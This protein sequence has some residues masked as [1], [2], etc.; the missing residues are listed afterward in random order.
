[1]F[2]FGKP[3]RPRAIAFDTVGTLIDLEPLRPLIT[4]MGL[5]GAGLEGWIGAGLRDAFALTASG[6]FAP[7]EEVLKGALDQVLAEQQLDP[8]AT[9]KAALF[10]RMLALPARS[11]SSVALSLLKE[12]GIAL[13]AFTNS[14]LATAKAMLTSG[15]IDAFFTGIV[16]TG[17]I[18]TF[19]PSG[20][21]YRHC[22]ERAG[23][24]PGDLMLVAA[25]PWDI[26]GAAVAGCR[27]G[28]LAVQRPMSPVFRQ[29][30]L[31]AERLPDLAE[32]ICALSP[33]LA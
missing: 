12:Q 28:Y 16:T 19:K 27:T 31:I 15:G 8:S 10:T 20:A 4:H 25:H 32:A 23:V 26:H 29:P 21:V 1:M 24:A 11:G 5:P 13:Y 18:E 14:S 7:F 9:D 2:G 3:S 33:E 6:S 17:E 22:A 30:D